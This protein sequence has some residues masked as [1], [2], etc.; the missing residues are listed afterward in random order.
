MHR[1]VLQVPWLGCGDLFLSRNIQFL[2]V[3]IYHACLKATLRD[4]LKSAKVSTQLSKTLDS[5]Y[6]F[7]DLPVD[8]STTLGNPLCVF[9]AKG[10]TRQRV[11]S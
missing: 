1:I 3:Q 11:L 10:V 2:L 7:K 5:Q 8:K 4:V 6:N 9:W